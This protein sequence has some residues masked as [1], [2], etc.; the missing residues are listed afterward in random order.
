MN[1]S[2]PVEL[3]SHEVLSRLARDDPH[4][5]EALRK[6]LI[7]SFIDSAPEKVQ[8]RLRGTQF[9]VDCVRRLSHSALGSTIKVYEPIFLS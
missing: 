3:P 2:L 6:Q 8:S 7:D 9:R 5:Y 1:A 4:A